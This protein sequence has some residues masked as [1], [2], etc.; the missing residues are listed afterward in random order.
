MVAH[1]EYEKKAC[2]TGSTTGSLIQDMRA[3]ALVS[4]LAHSICGDNV[5]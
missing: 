2:I 3:Y 5:G 4:L 1:T